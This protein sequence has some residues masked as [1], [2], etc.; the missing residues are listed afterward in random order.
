MSAFIIV[1]FPFRQI[2]VQLFSTTEART[3]IE[4]PPISLNIQISV[5]RRKK[6]VA[7]MKMSSAVPIAAFNAAFGAG[8]VLGAPA[9]DHYDV[10]LSSND[11]QCKKAIS[12][13]RTTP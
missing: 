12:R 9:L 5:E 10:S 7:I 13:R 2:N 11:L 1:L 6:H 8:E 3:T 4:L